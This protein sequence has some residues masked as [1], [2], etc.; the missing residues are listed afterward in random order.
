VQT[1][2]SISKTIDQVNTRLGKLIAWLIFVAVAVSTVNALIRKIFD[3]SSNSWL[4]LQWV[5]FGFVFLLCSPWTL[6]SNEHIRIDVI[7]SKLPKRARDWI[8]IVG[9]VAFLLPFALVMILTS[10]P[11]ALRSILGNEQSGNAGGLPQWP[12]KTLIFVGF[13]VLFVQGVSELIKRIA[14]MRGELEDT[15]SGG[16]H[17]ASAEAEAQRLLAGIQEGTTR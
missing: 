4:E 15:T 14:I 17:H 12:A 7:S 11:F 8:D 6:L 1:L 5:L 10:G 13:I 16:G 9:H 2:L 3:M